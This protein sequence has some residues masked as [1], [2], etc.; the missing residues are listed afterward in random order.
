LAGAS[1]E[2]GRARA[3]PVGMTQIDMEIPMSLMD[4]LAQYAGQDSPGAPPR[5]PLSAH[6]DFSQV[7]SQASPALLGG[8]IAQALQGA[9]EGFESSIAKLFQNSDPQP[10]TGLLQRLIQAAGPAV[11]SSFAGGALSHLAQSGSTA[12]EADANAITPT[13]AGELAGTARQSNPGIVAELGSFYS[14]HPTLVKT[15]G[16]AALAMAMS[17]MASR[18]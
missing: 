8:G 18:A 15:L 14:Q 12:Q 9:P 3:L 4:I 11:L 10:R 17:H 1:G 16:A 6:Q 7:A 2:L 5:P 13:Q